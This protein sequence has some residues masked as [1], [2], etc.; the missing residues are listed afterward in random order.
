MSVL[1]LSRFAY[2]KRKEPFFCREGKENQS[3]P[4]KAPCKSIPETPE[5]LLPTPPSSISRGKLKGEGTHAPQRKRRNRVLSTSD[6][7]EETRASRNLFS[8]LKASK[9]KKRDADEAIKP[10]ALKED[11]NSEIVELSSDDETTT[12]LKPHKT[13]PTH[14]KRKRNMLVF[15][16]EEANFADDDDAYIFEDGVQPQMPKK[17]HASVGKRSASFHGGTQGNWMGRRSKTVERTLQEHNQKSPCSQLEECG[18]SS[19][20]VTTVLASDE[21]QEHCKCHLSYHYGVPSCY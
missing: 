11:K 3:T 8:G 12:I 14:G 18:S 10:Y 15:S 20:A 1:D 16:F 17:S 7:E 9:R 21:M 13:E 19:E 6:E 5:S 4:N 2:Q